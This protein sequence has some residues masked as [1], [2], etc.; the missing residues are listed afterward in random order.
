[1][2]ARSNK[3]LVSI[4]AEIV[5]KSSDGII[6]INDRDEIIFA[7]PAWKIMHGFDPEEVI[8][9][10]KAF[11]ILF[12]DPEKRRESIEMWNH[13]IAL[14]NPPVHEVQRETRNG[15]KRWYRFQ[16]S[17]L[18]NGHK[19]VK[20]IDITERKLLELQFWAFFEQAPVAIILHD[21]ETGEII[22]FNNEALELLGYTRKELP[23]S[24]IYNMIA[25]LPQ[26]EITRRSQNTTRKGRDH[27][28]SSVKR[29]NGEIRHISVSTTTIKTGSRTMIQ[30]II[31]NITDRKVIET[32]MKESEEM[33]RN[34]AEQSPN[35]IFINKNRRV[36]YANQ[37]CE[38]TTG[39]SL[40]EM[41]PQEKL[42]VDFDK[43]VSM[44]QPSS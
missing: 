22:E 8:T 44:R 9:R 29:K 12:S 23:G 36:V 43:E 38:T 5:D 16:A 42:W 27:F 19:M 14:E 21:A 15:K 10:E 37:Q 30:A 39:Y 34:L 33:F 17:P 4:A 20:V 11:E 28:D 13:D 26:E 24:N 2:P 25:L 6:V 35:M 7:N 40:K 32:A 41:V 18:A 31:H 3:T 1:M